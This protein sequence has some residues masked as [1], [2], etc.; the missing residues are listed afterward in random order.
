MEKIKVMIVLSAFFFSAMIPLT[1]AEDKPADPIMRY[2]TSSLVVDMD[3]HYSWDSASADMID[4][5]LEG[6]F[7]YDFQDNNLAYQPC[8]AKDFGTWAE[9]AEGF[10]GKQWKYT[11]DLKTNITFH[12]GSTFEAEDVKY[13]FDRLKTLCTTGID[14]EATQVASLYMPLASTYPVTPLL[15]N[16][17]NIIDEDTV[18]LILNYKYAAL[19]TLLC[20]T[21]SVIMPK[22]KYP[23]DAYLDKTTDVL[24]GTGPY[25]QISHMAELTEFAYF[26]DFRGAYGRKA[27]EIRKMEYKL[28]S[29]PTVLNQAFLDG[30]IDAIG[31]IT[32]EF[33]DQYENSSL[34]V[35]G[36]RMQGTSISY[37]G[38][39]M[40]NID[41]NTRKALRSAINYT[42]ILDAD[43]CW[44]SRKGE[45]KALTSLVPAGIL[46]HDESIEAPM[47]NLAAARASIIA[48]VEAG[49]KMTTKPAGWD[50]LKQSTDNEDWEAVS[51]LSID[52][53]YHENNCNHP[54]QRIL[55]RNFAKIGVN[56]N[57]KG[58]QW[59][60]YLN[61]L[62][63]GEMEVY[64]L[65]WMPD[66]NDPSNYIDNLAGSASPSNNAHVNDSVLDGLIAQGLLETD[67]I[68]REQ[69]YKD[70]QKRIVAL[71]VFAF[72]ST[73]Y[74]RS[75]YNIGCQNTARNAMGKLYWYLWTFD[76]GASFY[77]QFGIIPGFSTLTLIA[78][79][80][81]SLSI[82]VQ[83][84]QD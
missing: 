82:L 40:N 5:I 17:T 18:E 14:G 48:A 84:R 64:S 71:S 24:I 44:E 11:V 37:I 59:E 60:A 67:P 2:G 52:H 42:D 23:T 12:D 32:L 57:I 49:E 76:A 62:R 1:D 41:I 73:N 22:D 65:G 33:M 46:Y 77:K 55:K 61:A 83:K 68:K 74:A 43:W 10:H 75:V 78:V 56:L 31:G 19:E 54:I 79:C 29:D 9:G 8:L 6:L 28:Y 45:R 53:A 21:G 15:I 34:H 20:F 27:P 38:F 13:S 35:V 30:D 69:L 39:D 25:T 36:D 3:P 81:L 51:I 72:F 58:F 16:A 50:A 80:T 63:S 4:Q 26:E 7:S 66:F 70:M 47:M